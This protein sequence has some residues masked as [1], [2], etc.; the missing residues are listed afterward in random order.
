MENK[1]QVED[2]EDSIEEE[3]IF[4]RKTNWETFLGFVLDLIVICL[5][6]LSAWW[7]IRTVQVLSLQL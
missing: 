2:M 1:E 4:A 3:E 5:F 7:C 6:P